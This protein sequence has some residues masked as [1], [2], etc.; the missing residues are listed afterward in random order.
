MGGVTLICVF[1]S[2]LEPGDESPTDLRV[3]RRYRR[4]MNARTPIAV[5]KIARPP[6]AAVAAIAA[7][8]DVFD[9]FDVPVVVA[10]PFTGRTGALD[11]EMGQS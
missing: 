7:M 2:V 4:R 1:T 8:C 3:L 10:V 11:K 5:N 6:A 9:D